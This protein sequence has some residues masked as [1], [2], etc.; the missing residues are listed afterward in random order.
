LRDSNAPRETTRRQVDLPRSVGLPVAGH[1]GAPAAI[2]EAMSRDKKARDG[3]VPFVLAPEIGRYRL[4]HDVPRSVVLEA[5]E[6][7][8]APA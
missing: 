6:E 8:A 3:R 7:L 5:L 4:V 2:V 1:G